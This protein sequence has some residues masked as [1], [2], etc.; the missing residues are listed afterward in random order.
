[1]A[2][3]VVLTLLAFA[4][5]F[6]A[7]Q[8]NK[9]I[10]SRNKADEAFST[11]DVYLRQ[12]FDLIP[13]LVATTK[14]YA[15]HEA[16]TLEKVIFA[17]NNKSHMSHEEQLKSEKQIS[18]AI[19]SINAI[20]EQYPDLKANAN[21]IQLGEKLTSLETDIAN[22]RKYYNAC[23]KEYNTGIQTFPGNIV[24]GLFHF[25]ER[26]LFEAENAEERKNVKVEF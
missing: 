7:T 4:G 6:I 1:M 24:A 23:V 11:M 16:K 13:N 25:K 17:R 15:K 3:I 14:G 21:F 8:Y 20:A 2:I 18:E 19:R 9:F 10:V 5:I 26:P 22:A 12:R